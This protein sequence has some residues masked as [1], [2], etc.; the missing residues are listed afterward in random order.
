M[1]IKGVVIIKIKVNTISFRNL[2]INKDPGGNK[3][4]K[5]QIQEYINMENY[6]HQNNINNYN[7][8]YLIDKTHFPHWNKEGR[9][10]ILNTIKCILLK[11]K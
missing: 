7:T 6:F 3:Y 4:S 2:Q 1:S 11:M 8:I 9:D 5:K 10:I